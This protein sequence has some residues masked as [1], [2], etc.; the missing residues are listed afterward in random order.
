MPQ[1]PP[2]ARPLSVERIRE[3]L[4]AWPPAVRDVVSDLP[5]EPD[6]A[7]VTDYH[8][9][10]EIHQRAGEGGVKVARASLAAKLEA[11]D[12][13]DAVADALPAGDALATRRLADVREGR[14][15]ATR[16]ALARLAA[17]HPHEEAAVAACRAEIE[18]ALAR[19]R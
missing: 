15:E 10:I 16:G 9:I 17:I 11:E 3:V 12:P 7:L 19:C 1:S 4:A 2:P 18:A 5:A 6:V 8:R 14:Q 13:P